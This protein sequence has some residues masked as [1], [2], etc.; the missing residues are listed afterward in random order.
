MDRPLISEKDLLESLRLQLN[1][2]SFEEVR[3]MSL[4]RNGGVSVVKKE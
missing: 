2:D 1:Q 4:E 3:E